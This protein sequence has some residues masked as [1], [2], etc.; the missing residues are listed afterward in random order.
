MMAKYKDLMDSLGVTTLE[1]LYVSLEAQRLENVRKNIEDGGGMSELQY[2]VFNTMKLRWIN[3]D[4]FSGIIGPRISMQ[5][6]LLNDGNTDVKAVF[7]SLKSVLPGGGSPEIT[8][9]SI[10]KKQAIYL[11]ALKFTNK[12]AYID[13]QDTVTK[14]VA[15]TIRFK[16]VTIDEL[17]EELRILDL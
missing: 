2:Y 14:E 4:A 9:A 15:D 6:N 8:I 16:P 13:I 12:Q 11:V 10:P 7:K 3:C 1:E 17:K 5:T